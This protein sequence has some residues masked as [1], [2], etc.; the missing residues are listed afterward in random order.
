MAQ[1]HKFGSE[2]IFMFGLMKARTCLQADE[3]KLHR[4]LH[5]C[6]TCKTMGRLYG[7]KTRALLNHDTVFLAEVLSAISINEGSLKS[8][9]R[10]YQSYNCL[11]LPD[12]DE[13]MPL[14]LQLAATA[15]VV[16]TEFKIA[17]HIQDSKRRIWKTAQQFFSNSFLEA[18]ARLKAW[19][20]PL[21]EL[22]EALFSQAAREAR[23]LE[24]D[25]SAAAILDDLAAPTAMATAL[26]CQHG[27]RLVEQESQ[28]QTMYALGYG[29]GAIAYLIDAI[30]DFEKDWRH[31]GFNAIGA[32]YKI[33]AAK[34]PVEI[35]REV[36]KKVRLLQSQI[37]ALLLHLPMPEMMQAMF[38]ARLHTNLSRKLGGLPVLNESSAQLSHQSPSQLSHHACKTGGR[39]CKTKMTI[40]ERWRNA[41]S[42]GREISNRQG[43]TDSPSFASRCASRIRAPFIFV[44]VL[45]MAFFA[46]HQMTGA[47]S[48]RESMSLGLNLM[49]IGSVISSIAM[50][51]TRPLRFSTPQGPELGTGG[52]LPQPEITDTVDAA[53]NRVN[54][55]RK[56]GDGNSSEGCSC[57]E[58]GCDCC[59]EGICHNCS[60]CD[61]CD[62]CGC[63]CN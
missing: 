31:G 35:R 59:G 5:Y 38:A 63:D 41:V 37:E 14:P 56:G 24:S 20:F 21:D 6:G 39:T 16:L 46:P 57:C 30:E 9:N 4:R 22:R 33:S 51:L 55:K 25:Q 13:Q 34:L 47:E 45:P 48:Y 19:Q 3:L 62:C 36:V 43:K 18:S 23:A 12:T 2:K 17:D 8:W 58:G 50:M 52:Q 26:F 1:S 10:A 42:F 49:F 29:F 7:Q 11:A 61:G 27:A 53:I 32:A 40:T 60:C 28:Q 54:K 15:T 44:S